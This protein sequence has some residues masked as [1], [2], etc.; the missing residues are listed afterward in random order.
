MRLA[1]RTGVVRFSAV[2]NTVRLSLV[3]IIA[4]LAWHATSLTQRSRDDASVYFLYD[5]GIPVPRWSY[6]L[7][8]YRVSLQARR[9]WGPG[10]V[11]L[12]R[13]D[14]AHLRAAL[15]HG[16][17]VILATHGEDGY[18]YAFN[19]PLPR[20]CAGTLCVAPPKTGATDETKNPGFLCTAVLGANNTW[21]KA[22]NLAVNGRLSL[23]YIFACHA[24]AKAA[25][26]QEHLAPAKVITYD[27]VSTPYDHGWW[28]AFA[29]PALLRD[30]R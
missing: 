24:G 11:V 14:E 19:N 26:W 18:A 29:G 13:L 17:V 25:Q 16:K 27:R 21:S 20:V 1:R 2:A 15:A 9:N 10:N 22:E 5:D 7:G 30:L 8:M 28:F 23:A 3:P 6:A 12:D 4:M